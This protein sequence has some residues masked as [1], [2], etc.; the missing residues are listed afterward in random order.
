M[1]RAHWEN[2]PATTIKLLTGYS[3]PMNAREA[4]HLGLPPNYRKLWSTRMEL[5]LI[6]NY[7]THTNIELAEKVK[8]KC[9]PIKKEKITARSVAKRLVFLGCHRTKEELSYIKGKNSRRLLQA[10][11]IKM[12]RTLE[13]PVGT[14]IFRSERLW[15]KTE[16][17]K[18]VMYKV[19]LYELHFGKI[20]S[21]KKVH[22]IDND[23]KNIVIENLIL[24]DVNAG[25]REAM[26]NKSDNVIIGYLKNSKP[27][28]Y[29]NPETINKLK[30]EGQYNIELKRLQLQLKKAIKGKSGR[31]QA[32]NWSPEQ[33]KFLKKNYGVEP[34]YYIYTSLDMSYNQ[35]KYK[36]DTLGL[37]GSTISMWGKKAITIVSNNMEY[38]NNKEIAK[39]LN[40]IPNY[41][42]RKFTSEAIKTFMDKT[43]LKRSPEAVKRM[44]NKKRK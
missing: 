5:I 19:Y 30:T 43:G 27:E 16:S 10:G 29:K 14:Y 42:K 35:V 4:K 12:P 36:A 1:L 9:W 20:P 22:V 17:N 25:L 31:M 24:Y 23:E 37:K 40:K 41:S 26:I 18:W 28:I 11:I 39:M 44:L 7:K 21:N 38:Y 3:F 33:E 6:A 34:M 2:E 32:L 8:E 13:H 15:Y